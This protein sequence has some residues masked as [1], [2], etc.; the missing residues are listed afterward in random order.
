MVEL[1]SDMKQMKFIVYLA[2]LATLASC[3]TPSNSAP[4]SQPDLTI[5]IGEENVRVGERTFRIGDAEAMRAGF[6]GAC[7]V[8]CDYVEVRAIP[9]ARYDAILAS[10]AAGVDHDAGAIL[11]RIASSQPVAL[12]TGAGASPSASCPAEVVLRHDA[13]D[14]YINGEVL[15]P[16]ADCEPWGATICS[17]PNQD[18][19]K[20]REID[21]LREIVRNYQ[22]RFDAGTCLYAENDMPAMLIDR[23]I[24]AVRSEAPG[25]T[26]ALRRDRRRGSLREELVTETIVDNGKQLTDCYDVELAET[27]R[28]MEAV[29]RILIGPQ[30]D[31]AR[32]AVRD[33]AMTT[34]RF[35]QCLIEAVQTFAFPKPDDG[36]TVEITYPLRFSP[37]PGLSDG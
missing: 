13:F 33:R 36:G 27:R 14:V 22:P 26:F 6:A 35:E 37:R 19:L 23:V 2:T 16:T 31:V 9:M 21:V 12:T 18:P 30:G 1:R 34:P 32:V 28:P 11:L 4:R 25:A 29:L 8:G 15:P 17:S 3:A 10:Y 5:S 24:H 7:G 20:R